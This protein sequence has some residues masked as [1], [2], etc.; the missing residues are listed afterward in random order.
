MLDMDLY[1]KAMAAGLDVSQLKRD[2][3]NQIQKI[4]YA[5]PKESAKRIT[6]GLTFEKFVLN[7]INKSG[8]KT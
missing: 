4:T 5:F 6:E 2:Y 3:E 1:R 8:P 7:A